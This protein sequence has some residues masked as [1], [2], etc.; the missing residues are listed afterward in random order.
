M[1]LG[2]ILL[3]ADPMKFS[4][5]RKYTMSGS[6]YGSVRSFCGYG[7][8]WLSQGTGNSLIS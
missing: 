7:Y 1:S 4:F 5:I 6:E 3:T 2:H 8:I